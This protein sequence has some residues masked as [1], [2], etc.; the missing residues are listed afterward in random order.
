MNEKKFANRINKMESHG[1]ESAEQEVVETSG[2]EKELSEQEITEMGGDM[3][4]YANGLLEHVK[5]IKR[6]LEDAELEEDEKQELEFELN[7]SEEQLLGLREFVSDID[8]KDYE[9]ITEKQK[10]E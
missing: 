8:N 3:K 2:E 5:E 1:N 4:N 6:K 9:E 10:T 7:D